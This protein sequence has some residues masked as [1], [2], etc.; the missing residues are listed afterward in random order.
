MFSTTL[1]T[2]TRRRRTSINNRR[3]GQ[4]VFL[5]SSEET[6]PH[7]LVRQVRAGERLGPVSRGDW[8][9]AGVNG[10]VRPWRTVPSRKPGAHNPIKC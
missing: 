8:S 4:T 1:L 7:T 6:P 2:H 9:E 5:A 10:C 3:R